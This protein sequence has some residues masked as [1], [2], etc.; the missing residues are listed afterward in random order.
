M[1]PP[2]D[3]VIRIHQSIHGY[4]EGHRQL[5]SSIELVGQDTL[6]VLILS[7]SSADV[8]LL[9]TNGYLTGYPLKESGLYAF[10][11]TWP[12]PEISRP[13]CVWTHTL[14]IEYTDLA[15]ISD[16][17]QLLTLFRKPEGESSFFDYASPIRWKKLYESD[18]ASDDLDVDLI[19][20]A[21]IGLYQYPNK[22][23]QLKT[24]SAYFAD[25][26]ACLIWSQQWPRLRRTFRFCTFM[27][28]DRS[29]SDHSFD[30]QF[31]SWH[32][33]RASDDNFTA[34]L[35][36]E[37]N[38][39]PQP[40]LTTALDDIIYGNTGLRSFLRQMGSDFSNGRQYFAELC[41]QYGLLRSS[42]RPPDAIEKSLTFVFD[43]VPV[44][45]GRVLRR[46]VAEIAVQNS[47]KLS[48]SA[49]DSLLKGLTILPDGVLANYAPMLCRRIWRERPKILLSRSV[50]AALIDVLPQALKESPIEDVVEGLKREPE[51]AARALKARPELA[52]VP[53]LWVGEIG[54]EFAKAFGRIRRKK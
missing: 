26:T 13:G 2:N 39:V 27:N 34:Q 5:K 53:A 3:S 47:N 12:A 30:L 33:G 20:N 11:K 49:F 31:S 35:H 38:D 32:D 21:L 45:E 8:S 37:V 24:K 17:K 43:K 14:L 9:P 52:G 41:T 19:K 28:E 10:A 40:W 29:T 16:F 36:N 7:D 42:Q 50:N 48:Q 44:E 18:I 54:D 51:L 22:R 23:V 4:S 25:S 46:S 15:E 1:T 6:T